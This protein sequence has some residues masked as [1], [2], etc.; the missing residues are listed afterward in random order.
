SLYGRRELVGLLWTVLADPR[1]LVEQ[2]RLAFVRRE[3]ERRRRHR[4]P[5]GQLVR[6]LA[7]DRE[8]VR[9]GERDADVEVQARGLRGPFGEVPREGAEHGVLISGATALLVIGVPVAIGIGKGR[10]GVRAGIDSEA[11]DPCRVAR[12]SHVVVFAL[13]DAEDVLP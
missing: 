9:V 2:D 5:G 12:V 10:A 13:A 7:G 11:L 8:R 4:R 6:D 3:R 1:L